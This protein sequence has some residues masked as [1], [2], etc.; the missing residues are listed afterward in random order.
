MD[1][2]LPDSPNA[3][4]KAQYLSHPDIIRSYP[5]YIVKTKGGR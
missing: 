3:H 2:I 1:E 5:M 4:V